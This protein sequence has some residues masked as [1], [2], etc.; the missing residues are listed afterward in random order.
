MSREQIEARL[1]RLAHEVNRLSQEKGDLFDRIG[2]EV[3]A[4]RA[5]LTA[6]AQ[7][8]PGVSALPAKWRDEAD[9]LAG[10]SAHHKRECATELEAVLAAQDQ[11]EGNGPVKVSRFKGDP[12]CQQDVRDWLNANPDAEAED[13]GR[14]G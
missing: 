4:I 9:Y 13:G 3:V 8:A 2:D 11:G 1:T 7:A 14:L 5:A 6:S 10:G 12:D